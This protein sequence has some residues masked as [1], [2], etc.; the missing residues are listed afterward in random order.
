MNQ[1]DVLPPDLSDIID[2]AK[3]DIFATMNCVQI[4]KIESVDNSKQIV[5][6]TLQIKRV[7]SDDSSVQ[8]PMLVDCPYFVLS[9]GGAYIDMPIAAGDYCIVLFNDRDIDTWWDSANVAD[10][11]TNRKHDISDGIAIIGISPSTKVY[12]HDGSLIRIIGT[13]GGESANIKE[14]ARK[15]DEVKSTSTEDSGF[16]SWI[17]GFVSI[18]T[19]WVPVP[20]DGGAALKTAL[21]TF[22]ASNPTPSSLT[23]KITSG[24]SEV[25]IG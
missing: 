6:V 8:I 7:L 11:N 18:F 3:K 14:A 19:S 5:S 23:G 4:G 16:W 1:N 12:N 13:S 24:S 10:P 2:D 22:F 17:T 9:G 25:K 20:D 21:S 15:E